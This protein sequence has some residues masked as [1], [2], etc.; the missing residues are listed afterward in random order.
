MG[1]RRPEKK[2]DD[3]RAEIT[4]RLLSKKKAAAAEMSWFHQAETVLAFR[5]EESQRS[6]EQKALIERF[7]QRLDEEIHAEASSQ[8]AADLED[9]QR[10]IDR[11]DASRPDEP[12]RAY[13]FY[14]ESP[15]P[16]STRILERGDPASPGPEVQ[17]G[18]P[19]VFGTQQDQISRLGP[20]KAAGTHRDEDC[21]WPGG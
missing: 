18:V 12:P 2:L 1:N 11:L 20:I 5:T 21:G 19:T 15:Q 10:E 16:S 6:E 7:N 3:L 13:V 14:E 9:W 17:P 4:S 8:E